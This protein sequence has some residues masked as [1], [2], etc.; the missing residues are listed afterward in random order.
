MREK[1]E[2]EGEGRQKVRKGGYGHRMDQISTSFFFTNFPE[3]LVWG[4]LWKLFSRYGSVCD[5]FIPKK[6]DKWGRKF[7]FVKFKEVKDEE[8]ELLSKKLEDVWCEKFKLRINRARFGKGDIKEAKGSNHNNAQRSLMNLNREVSEELSFKS[9][10]VGKENLEGVKVDKDGMVV[11]GDGGRK[12]T[13]VFSMGDLVPLDISVQK[14]TVA[15]LKQCMVGFFKQGMDFQTFIDRLLLEGQHDVKPTFMGGNMVLLHC[16]CDGELMEVMKA[17]KEWWDNTF[18][19]VIPW[20]PNLVSESRET[21]IQLYGI[22]LHAWEEGTFKMVAG[23]LGVFMD[24]DEATVAK[25]RLDVARV[26]LRTVRRGMIDTVIQLKVQ[27]TRFDVWVVEERCGCGEEQQFEGDRS[28][29]TNSSS[30]DC[31]WRGG[32]GDVFSEGRTDSERSESEEVLSAVAGDNRGIRNVDMHGQPSSVMKI[33]E[34]ETGHPIEKGHVEGEGEGY[35][36]I[37][38]EE[39]VGERPGVPGVVVGPADDNSK[40]PNEV[41]VLPVEK[42]QEGGPQLVG[43]VEEGRCVGPFGPL[44]SQDNIVL[45]GETQEVDAGI[46]IQSCED[47]I[48]SQEVQIDTEEVEDLDDVEVN[49]V[50][51]GTTRYSQIS[52]SHHETLP[53]TNKRKGKRNSRPIPP[54]IGVPKFCQLANSLIE[55]GKR[56][57]EGSRKKVREGSGVS[58]G[59]ANCDLL[60]PHSS[61][62]TQ[63]EEEL[64]AIGLQVVLPM[65]PS[66]INL[67][68]DSNGDEVSDSISDTQRVVDKEEE[69]TLLIGI[70]KEVGFTFEVGEEE[71]Q[72]KLVELENFDNEQ[73]TVRVQQRGF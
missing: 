23:R 68:V 16:A 37:P 34:R 38:S 11:D 19:K 55:A 8:V 66:G 28:N 1:E 67:I 60:S 4:D 15:L 65:P 62:S 6:V 27:G 45:V 61:A 54:Q 50:K 24:F 44:D 3:E 53:D 14:T 41:S 51:E 17:N 42:D 71:I 48:L 43:H 36:Q 57:K 20:K 46:Q 10:L 22:P 49:T 13:R 47:P 56:K 64:S 58:E 40:I 5:V 72:S 29:K 21:W 35:T 18:T 39:V 73:K 30:G 70:Q 7:G 31:A 69:A 9:L 26:K 63:E 2:R 25:H 33:K 32:D 12:K 52:E 59:G